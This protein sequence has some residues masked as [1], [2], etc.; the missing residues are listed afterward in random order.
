MFQS[1]EA[2]KL[3]STVSGLP[4]SRAAISLGRSRPATVKELRGPELL[5]GAAGA[6]T[7]QPAHPGKQH[8]A[9]PAPAWQLNAPAP[10]WQPD[11]LGGRHKCRGGPPG[12]AGQDGHWSVT[13]LPLSPNL[14]V[15]KNSTPE[16]YAKT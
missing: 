4:G 6:E 1:F 16:Q 5:D 11:G 7:V 8:P 9:L 2:Q 10:G 14:K 3:I 12:A 13:P 15:V